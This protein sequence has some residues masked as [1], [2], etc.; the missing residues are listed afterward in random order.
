MPHLNRRA[1]M[2]NKAN[3][4][5]LGVGRW[6]PGRPL[7]FKILYY[8]H[9]IQSQPPLFEYSRSAPGQGLLLVK[10]YYNYKSF[11]LCCWYNCTFPKKMGGRSLFKGWRKPSLLCYIFSTAIR[12]F[13]VIMCHINYLSHSTY[14]SNWE[15]EL[16]PSTYFFV[17]PSLHCWLS[18]ILSAHK[19]VCYIF[20]K[21]ELKTIKYLT[22]QLPL[23]MLTNNI[24]W[25][26][27]WIN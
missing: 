12:T 23:F 27:T 5:R 15:L 11:W 6:D 17:R 10:D 21:A 20:K 2:P 18:N 3:M 25:K 1:G 8:F 13:Y 24:H 26:V 14:H 4:G 22:N 19:W 7:S 16:C 9:R